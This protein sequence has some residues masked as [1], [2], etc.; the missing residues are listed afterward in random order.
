MNIF[1]GN[2]SFRTEDLDLRAHFEQYGTVDSAVII[3]D[4]ETGKSRGYGFVEMPV[5]SQAQY[6]IVSV[7]GEEFMGREL[8]CNE[9]RP[10]NGSG[11]GGPGGPSERSS[12]KDSSPR[13]RGRADRY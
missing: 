11:R 2:L 6:A 12:S 13:G 10:R 7:N 8:T 3:T 9:A 5:D 1:V 4:R